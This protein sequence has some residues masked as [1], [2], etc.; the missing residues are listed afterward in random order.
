[1]K[2]LNTRFREFAIFILSVLVVAVGVLLYQNF[3]LMSR[4]RVLEK[5][6]VRHSWMDAGLCSDVERLKKEIKEVSSEVSF[7]KKHLEVIGFDFAFDGIVSWYGDREH[8]RISAS[9]A[10]FDKDAF[11]LAHRSLPFG[12]R[13]LIENPFNGVRVFGVVTDRGPYIDGRVADVSEGLAKAL[14]F[15]NEGLA[16]LK[17]YNVS[18]GRVP[19]Q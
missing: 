8:G 17:F 9:G 10:V 4:I 15:H 16:Y 11:T 7:L 5:D 19:L 2:D 18:V 6:M 14:G 3:S 1:M 13:L 12:T